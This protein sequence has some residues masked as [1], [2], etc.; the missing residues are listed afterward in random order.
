MNAVVWGF[1]SVPSFA[2]GL[3]RDP[4]VRWALREAGFPYE[5][6]LI[7]VEERT[8][9]A[10]RERHPFGMVPVFEANGRQLI[11]SGAIVYAIAK[12]SPALMPEDEHGRDETLALCQ[13]RREPARKRRAFVAG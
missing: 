1:R 12:R 5:A 9:P 11:E 8:S 10:H 3:V 7:G 2:Q 13:W 4:R 6:K